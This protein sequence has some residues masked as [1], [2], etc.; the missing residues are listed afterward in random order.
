MK[1]DEV[2]AYFYS[3]FKEQALHLLD[4]NILVGSLQ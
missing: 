4:C 3:F 1:L 2:L